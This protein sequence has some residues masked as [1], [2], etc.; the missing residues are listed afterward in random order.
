MSLG[1]FL[2]LATIALAL[3]VVTPFLG[4][5]MYRVMEGERTFLSP[6]LRP[7]ERTIYR[8]CGIDETAEHDWKAYAISVMAMAFV[9]IVAGYVMLRLQD[10]LPLEPEPCPG[11][12][13]GPRVQHLGQLR[14]QH[15][16]AELLRRDR[17]EPPDPGDDARGP[18]LHVRGDGPGDRDR[19]VPR[20]DPTDD[21]VARQLLG[22]P[23]PRRALHP[24]AD[25]RRRRRRPRL[26]GRPPDVER[27]ADRHDPRRRA[28]DDRAGA[29]RLPG[30]RSRRSAT[31]A[32]AS[33]T[34][35]RPIRSRARRRSRTGSRSSACSR[36]P[37]R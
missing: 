19:A 10:V 17:G 20:P 24:A 26:A 22:R 15:E 27:S 14:D 33:S 6:I 5:Y 32:A 13:A 35:T 37:S 23:D 4:R 2:T 28:A 25:R 30:G 31:T 1:D 36:S 9:A 34:R 16:L 3:L 11:D 29:D 18:Q 12:V 21:E 7:V 8:L